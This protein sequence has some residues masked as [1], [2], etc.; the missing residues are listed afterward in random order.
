MHYSWDRNAPFRLS[1][2][3]IPIAGEMQIAAQRESPEIAY[4]KSF[5]T[6]WTHA[7]PDAEDI[8]EVSAFSAEA[9]SDRNPN[10]RRKQRRF[11]T[12]QCVSVTYRGGRTICDLVELSP[13][14]ARLRIVSGTVPA[15]A[16]EVSISLLNGATVH[17]TVKW[18][19]KSEIGVALD[20]AISDVETLLMFEDLG[21]GFYSAAL[22]L[23]RKSRSL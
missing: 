6:A 3:A 20:A 21:E 11:E 23:Q 1:A 18:L 15:I 13:Q 4:M 10:D 8:E 19:G 17:G 7:S 22:R 5:S 9:E 16:S 2:F 12:V 14:G